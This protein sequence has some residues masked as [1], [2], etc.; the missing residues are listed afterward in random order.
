[1]AKVKTHTVVAIS[2]EPQ[3]LAAAK[4]AAKDDKRS[5][6]NWVCMLIEAALN[7]QAK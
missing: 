5:F 3:L 2:I 7:T 6:S 4:Q 1:M